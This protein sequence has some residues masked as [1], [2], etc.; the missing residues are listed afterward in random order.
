[1]LP[2]D[3]G[4]DPCVCPLFM[5]QRY[6]IYSFDSDNIRADPCVCPYG[7]GDIFQNSGGMQAHSISGLTEFPFIYFL[8]LLDLF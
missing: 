4:A 7:R 2:Q 5:F 3:V 6:F 1:M 8:R